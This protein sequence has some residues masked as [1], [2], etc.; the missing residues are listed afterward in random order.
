MLNTVWK[1]I[2]AWFLKWGS[3]KWFY[4][5]SK[6]WSLISGWLAT[7]MISW[8]FIYGIFYTPTEFKGHM[9]R[10]LYIH[11][12]SASLSMMMY[13]AIGIMAV[14]VLVWKMKMSSVMLK[15]TAQVGAG[16][17]V[18]MFVTGAIWGTPAWGQGIV[19]DPRLLGDGILVLLY[20]GILAVYSAIDSYE[21]A[22][23]TV[24]VLAICT[25]FIL[26]FIK[27]A[28]AMEGLGMQSIHQDSSNVYS[29][30]DSAIDKSYQRPLLMGIFGFM[31]MGMSLVLRQAR[32]EVLVR[33][34]TAK[35]VQAIFDKELA[36]GK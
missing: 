35:W 2:V 3:P 23:K 4:E 17:A 26:V 22:D 5:Q 13:F 20:F 27:Y 16:F 25:V 24:A 9:S 1:T 15:S 28:P 10:A 21:Q 32:V 12:P 31:V 7:F 18:V 14:I 6:I 8:A 36:K 30:N 11:V 29:G 33:Y 19:W 34:R